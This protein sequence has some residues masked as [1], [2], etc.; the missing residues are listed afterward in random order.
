MLVHSS[1]S[2]DQAVGYNGTYSSPNRMWIFDCLL[3]SKGK[4]NFEV[5]TPTKKAKDLDSEKMWLSLEPELYNAY[6][7]PRKH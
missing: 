5:A 4:G 6:I 7:T 1:D 2:M 3:Y